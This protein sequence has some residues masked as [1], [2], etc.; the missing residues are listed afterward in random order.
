MEW[1]QRAALVPCV[2][3]PLGSSVGP[4]QVWAHVC[5]GVCYVCAHAWSVRAW[6]GLLFLS[7]TFSLA[8]ERLW[9]WKVP[10]G[11]AMGH[12][13]T[14]PPVREPRPGLHMLPG[15]GATHPAFPPGPSPG[16]LPSAF[17]GEARHG[18]PSPSPD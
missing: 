13:Q 15:A 17:S 6:P 5:A 1:G 4:Q 9:F 11:R 7:L 18:L 10:S 12:I 14:S 16:V 8:P 2:W 3:G